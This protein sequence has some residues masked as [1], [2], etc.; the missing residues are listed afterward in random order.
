MILYLVFKSIIIGRIENLHIEI[1]LDFVSVN[2][3]GWYPNFWIL[4]P[5]FANIGY[6]FKFLHDR[7]LWNF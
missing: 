1:F 5:W 6:A 3:D 2:D 4:F 7:V